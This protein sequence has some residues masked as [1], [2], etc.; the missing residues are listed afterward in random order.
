[1][2]FFF[3]L[4][5]AATPSKT[6][7]LIITEGNITSVGPNN[8]SHLLDLTLLRLTGNKI[9]QL[10]DGV[11]T[12]LSKL[13]TLVLDHNLIS[14]SSF[15]NTV[16]LPLGNLTIL[17]LNNNYFVSI[18]QN[19]FIGTNQ[20]LRLEINRN[21]ITNLTFRSFGSRALHR[22][23]YLEL[24]DNSIGFIQEGT[25]KHLQSLKVLDLSKNRL[26][27]LPNIFPSLPH[28][29]LL[30]LGQNQWNCT[31]ELRWVADFL[32]N[33][34][35]FPTETLNYG[36]GLQCSYSRDP[37]VTSLLQLTER[38]CFYKSQNVSFAVKERDSRE[39]TEAIFIS[40]L[41]IAGNFY[42]LEL[43]CWLKGIF[44]L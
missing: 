17:Q 10:Q 21:Q 32:R 41:V 20:L 31:C 11:F 12:K 29:S 16:F 24:S 38:N 35:H 40:I 37:R 3:C 27:T 44:Q 23:E 14:A 33:S 34:T 39:P 22:L 36:N 19:W 9:H 2:F 15:I 7:I 13:R 6:R 8:F 28:L 25:F 18:D 42:D 5:F 1:M 43:Y 26:S 30:N 4:F